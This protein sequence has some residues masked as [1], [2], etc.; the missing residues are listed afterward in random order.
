[1]SLS[2]SAASPPVPRWRRWRLALRVFAWCLLAVWSLALGLWLTLH[3]GILPRLDAWRPRI[4]AEASRALGVPVL[5]GRI[6]VHSSGWVPALA[7]DDVVLRDSQGREALRLPHVAA[8][9]SAPALLAL[10]LRFDQL[11]IDGPRLEVRRDAQ[12]RLH[13]AGLDLTGEATGSSH[14]LADWFFEQHELVIRGGV[15]RWVDEQRAAPPLALTD[16]QLVMRNR[17]GHHD[18]RLDATPPPAWGRRLTLVATARQP[19]QASVGL[20]HAG[21]WQQWKGS[22]YADLPEVAL[23]DLRRHV[24]LPFELASGSGALRAWIDFDQGSASAGTVDVALRD[25]SV[26]LARGIAPLALAEASGRFVAERQADGARVAASRLRF[27]TPEGQ[28]WPASQLSL[29][30]RQG[31]AEGG[32]FAADRL[33]LALLASLAG[34]LPIG[35]GLRHLLAALQPVGRVAPISARWQGALDAPRKYEVKATITG[36]GAQAAASAEPNAVGRPGWRGAD[37]E[38]TATESGG[39]AKL[40]LASGALELPGVF[41][42]PVVPLTH[43]AAQLQWRIQ[44]VA[45]AAPQIELKVTEA[46]FDNPDVKGELSATWRTGAGVGTGADINSASGFGRNARLPGVLELQGTLADAPATRI[47]RYLPRGIPARTRDYVRRAVQGGQVASA[48]YRV[49]GDLWDFPYINRK[50]GEFRVVAQ[51][52]NASF[53]Y[54]PSVPAEGGEPAFESPWPALQQV[55]GELSFDR[56]AMQIRQGRARLWGVELSDVSGGIRELGPHSTLELDGSARGPLAD[57]LKY[58]N[59]TPIGGWLSG[60]L[61]QAASSGPAELKLALALPFGQLDHSTVKGSLLL[62]GADLRLKPDLPQLAN[63]RGR[64]EF[65]QQ[66]LQLSS[67]AVKALGGDAVLDGGTQADGSLRFTASG[68]A[69]AEGLRHA[70]EWPLLPLLGQHLAGQAPYRA[71]LG[72]VHGWPELLVQS[73][74]TGMSSALPAPLGKAAETSLALRVQTTLQPET[75]G[76]GQRD[77]LRVDLGSALQA[78]YLRDLSPDTPRV[79]RGAVAINSPLPE[80][81]AGVVAQADLAQASAETWLGLIPDSAGAG[82]GAVAG[83]GD[84]GTGYMPQS[85]QLKA[86]E[87]TAASRRLTNLSL[88][89]QRSPGNDGWRARIDADQASGTVDYREPRG[90]TEAG[91]I[92]ARLARLALPP[93]DADNV[94]GLLDKVPA[95]V[96]ALD[97]EIEDFELRGRKLGRLALMAFNRSRGGVESAREWQLSQLSLKTPDAELA[98]TGQWGAAVAGSTRRR[99]ALDFKL[100]MANAGRLLDQ[101]GYPAVIRGGKGQLAGQ[102]SWAGSP[103]GLDLPS[104][105]GQMTLALDAGQF[106]KAEPGAGR[107]LGVLS[108]QSLPRR[109]VLDFRDLFQEGFAFDNVS[110]D[111]RLA[112]GVASTNNFRMRGAAAAVLIEGQSDVTRETQDLRVV[113]VPEINAGNASL[114]Y[115]AINPAIGL[116]TFLGQWL[117]R[118][119]L[120]EAGTREFRITGG[121]DD[122]QVARV[123]RGPVERAPA[124]RVAGPAATASAPPRTP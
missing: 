37:I 16:V 53:A 36:S 119:P 56:N 59:T 100:G 88:G 103:L 27:T 43:L 66:G 94:A 62:Q 31:A 48:T 57:M 117:L 4:E 89:L 1:M 29:G 11:L 87:F 49:K 120:R 68:T 44:P 2:I 34:R 122:P 64:V 50:A 55:D 99:M 58:V 111:L 14:E 106:L 108:M 28:A 109:L 72:F 76:Q 69:S 86:R 13:V 54:V 25:I 5:I 85:I 124:E 81:A 23:A 33:D 107:L 32:D 95:T 97:I 102:V 63:A 113:V 93:A 114:A 60:T 52:R 22:L 92:K 67:I 46:R 3:W 118:G 110:A 9:L 96:P 51:L 79:L 21:D 35:D 7:L 15:V 80:M 39:Q 90:A 82:A 74:L 17:L 10:H 121:W 116:G 84:A 70:T 123:E 105:D 61:A 40:T 71:Q 98:A 42:D 77:L 41:D 78:Q 24:D 115:A 65:T 45:N 6:R 26:R 19:W 30:W 104:L 12:G 18:M 91:S 73:P 38:L 83:P 20:M 75:R 8:A 47:A 101:L 112:Q